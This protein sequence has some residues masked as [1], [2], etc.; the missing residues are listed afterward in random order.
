MR[1][2]TSGV[3]HHPTITVL[4]LHLTVSIDDVVKFIFLIV[5]LSR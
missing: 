1:L 3:D 4:L 2:Y 5:G